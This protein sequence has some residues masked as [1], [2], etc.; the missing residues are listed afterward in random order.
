M[1]YWYKKLNVKNF[2]FRDPVFTINKK[3]TNLLCNEIINS[4]YKFNFAAE[5][6]L[7]DIDDILASKLSR[8]GLKL[9]FVGIESIDSKVLTDAHRTT[10]PIDEQ[11]LNISILLDL[12]NLL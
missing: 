11:S 12:D 5:F 8:A 10:I 6:H 7:K 3:Y 1:I 2:Q 4:G 9:A